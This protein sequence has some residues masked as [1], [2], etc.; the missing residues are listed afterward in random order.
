MLAPKQEILGRPA[1]F[2]YSH[3]AQS[4]WTDCYPHNVRLTH[5]LGDAGLPVLH[6][7]ARHMAA[8][9]YMIVYPVLCLTA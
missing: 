6:L 8:L 3:A 2:S 5:P 9:P 4:W 7:R 1:Q